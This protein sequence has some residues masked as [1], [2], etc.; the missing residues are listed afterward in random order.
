MHWR[1]YDRLKSLSAAAERQA[2]VDM[3]R[4]LD[5]VDRRLRR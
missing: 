2:T 5:R 1:A 3:M 4:A